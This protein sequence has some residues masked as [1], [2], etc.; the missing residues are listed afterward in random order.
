MWEQAGKPDGADFSY[1]ARTQLQQQLASGKSVQ[2]LENA[3]R[4]PKQTAPKQEAASQNGD[5]QNGN[6]A[7]VGHIYD[8]KC[9]LD[10]A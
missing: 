7:Q 9:R 5:K 8:S 10:R 1:D 2:D 3:L 4:G 6:A